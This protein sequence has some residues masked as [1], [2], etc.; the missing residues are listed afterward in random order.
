MGAARTH[1]IVGRA[2]S[3]SSKTSTA[4]PL[5]PFVPSGTLYASAGTLAS[6]RET[7]VRKGECHGYRVLAG[8][9]A[10]S[11]AYQQCG[12]T[13]RSTFRCQDVPRRLRR[14]KTRTGRRETRQ[15]SVSS[16]LGNLRHT[17]G[18][19]RGDRCDIAVL[20]SLKASTSRSVAASKG[21]GL[22]RLVCAAPNGLRS[23]PRRRES[24]SRGSSAT[25]TMNP[26]ISVCRRGSRRSRVARQTPEMPKKLCG[27]AS[28]AASVGRRARRTS[29]HAARAGAGNAREAIE[30]AR[31]VRPGPA[32]RDRRAGRRPST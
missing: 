28:R 6:T 22:L 9:P 29:P 10:R 20:G 1:L 16:R 27:A 24:T 32:T 13:H 11:G 31:P 23:R 4:V 21:A 19:Q 30:A 7:V 18:T 17:L 8:S 14:G 3:Q 26:A 2:A 5:P 15:E 12:R 25:R